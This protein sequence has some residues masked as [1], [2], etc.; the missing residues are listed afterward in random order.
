MAPP[1]RTTFPSI[2]KHRRA[3]RKISQNLYE[4]NI[5]GKFISEPALPWNLWCSDVPDDTGSFYDALF[6][7]YQ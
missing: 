5:F 3:Y 2:K 7:G 4:Q 1:S 6:T